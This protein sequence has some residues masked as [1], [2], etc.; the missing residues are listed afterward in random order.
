MATIVVKT[1][2]KNILVS[3]SGGAYD[4]HLKAY[5]N[6]MKPYNFTDKMRLMTIRMEH[7]NKV[8][9]HKTI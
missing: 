8:M 1:P 5:T 9:Y 4:K 6:D 7:H 3:N 2:K